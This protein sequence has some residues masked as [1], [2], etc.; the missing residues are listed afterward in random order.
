[1]WENV[2]ILR[3]MTCMVGMWVLI[4]LVSVFSILNMLMKKIFISQIK[5]TRVT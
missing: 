2:K 4:I 3:E 5:Y 1:M